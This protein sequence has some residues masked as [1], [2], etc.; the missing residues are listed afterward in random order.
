MTVARNNSEPALGETASPLAARLEL[1]IRRGITVDQF[2]A[3][4]VRCC[5][6]NPD[7]VW[8]LLALLDQYHRL[9]KL[10]TELF[11]ALKAAADRYGLVHHEPY[12][13]EVSAAPVPVAPPVSAPAPATLPADPGSAPFR[14]L[15]DAASTGADAIMVDD[16]RHTWQSGRFVR[17]EPPQRQRSWLRPLLLVILLA[18]VTTGAA[19]SGL[20]PDIRELI[21]GFATVRHADVDTLSPTAPATAP[22]PASASASVNPTGVRAAVIDGPAPVPPAPAAT[23]EVKTTAVTATA[24]PATIELSAGHYAVPPGDSA[25]RIVVRRDGDLQG[26]VSFS[27]WTENATA[28]ADVDYIAWGHRSE[29]IPA[30]RSSV[31]LLV[32]IINDATRTAARSFSVIRADI[33]GA[34]PAAT[35]RATVQL[36]GGG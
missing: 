30:G 15:L 8:N 4:M 22:A 10:P 33:K 24:A 9:E 23:A 26:E 2:E 35:I 5:A 31:T 34:R 13:P 3:D 17:P 19:L 18:A 32:P 11:R 20:L 7:E 14:H 1:L 16:S 12:I 28:Q 25:A 6:A 29:R 21:S 36:A 27:W